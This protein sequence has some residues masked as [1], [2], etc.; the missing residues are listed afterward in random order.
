MSEES[1]NLEPRR[2][3]VTVGDREIEVDEEVAPLASEIL[4]AGID[5]VGGCKESSQVK[6]VFSGS[7]ELRR[8]LNIVGDRD[9]GFDNLYTRIVGLDEYSP[10]VEQ[11]LPEWKY[12]VSVQDLRL[13]EDEGEDE[14]TP[15]KDEAEP[16]FGWTLPC[17]SRP[18]SSQSC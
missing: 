7:E 10:P 14:S 1:A 4:N 9:L 13:E 15:G 16:D 2:V 12:R 8:F 17:T 6:L 5:V 18:V 3:T 11:S